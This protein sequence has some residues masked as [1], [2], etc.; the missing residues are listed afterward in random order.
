MAVG[1]AV[2]AVVSALWPSLCLP[3]TPASPPPA[4]TISASMSARSVRN[5]AG[6]SASSPPPWRREGLRRGVRQAAAKKSRVEKDLRDGQTWRPRPLALR[7]RSEV[8][9]PIMATPRGCPITTHAEDVGHRPVLAVG[10]AHA[11]AAVHKVCRFGGKKYSKHTNSYVFL[12]LFGESQRV[13]SSQ[14]SMPQPGKKVP[15]ST[16]WNERRGR[17]RSRS[18]AA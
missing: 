13:S 7:T 16:R 9:P 5:I 11:A 1:G 8:P 3:P 12:V 14:W 6:L 15:T 17:G 4:T 2:A 18:T 10:G